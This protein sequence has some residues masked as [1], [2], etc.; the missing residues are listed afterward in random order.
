MLALYGAIAYDAS[1]SDDEM[2]ANQELLPPEPEIAGRA[3][4]GKA[5]ANSMSPERRRAVAAKAAA[6]RWSR[7]EATTAQA[8]YDGIL[9]IGDREIAC[10]VLSNGQRILSRATVLK[11][12][13]RT[14][15]AKGGRLYDEDLPVFLTA[16][17]LQPFISDELREL[18]RPLPY[19]FRGIQSI[20]YRAELLPLICLVFQDAF[21][22]DVL[23][24]NQLQIA[25]ACRLLYR[26]LAS[27]GII[28]LVD[29][30]TG[31]Q[32]IRARDELSQILAAYINPE[33]LP[34]QR[35]FPP[36]F[37]KEM[38]RVFGWE[39]DPSN[40]KR[41]QYVGKLTNKLIYEQLPSGVLDELR[42]KNPPNEN[43]NRRNRHHQL[44]TEDIGNHHLQHQVTAVT[45]LFRAA[46]A[47]GRA[48]FYRLFDAAFPGQQLAL[49]LPAPEDEP[50]EA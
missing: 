35:R 20:G 19:K 5:R 2:L 7:D 40:V 8:E 42:R 18:A 37:Y 28:A 14:G 13:G 10:A 12:M 17:N 16:E 38:F 41:T 25:E 23:K 33:L 50:D 44:L 9:K 45:T 6:A 3:K 1:M 26:G 46:P 31:Y 27:V 29:E 48:E 36:S 11:A 30:A 24:K 21:D 32:A 4:G 34:W 47:N 39:Y 15:K 49:A 43:G 22:A